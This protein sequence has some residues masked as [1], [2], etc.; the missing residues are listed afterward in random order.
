MR[1]TRAAT[2]G[3]A[4]EQ[5]KAR[6]STPGSLVALHLGAP[7]AAINADA[8]RA[9]LPVTAGPVASQAMIP[10]SRETR[11]RARLSQPRLGVDPQAAMH[12]SQVPAERRA[13]AGAGRLAILSFRRGHS[14]QHSCTSSAARVPASSIRRSPSSSAKR[15][16][17]RTARIRTARD[18]RGRQCRGPR[19]CR[20]S[21]SCVRITR[22]RFAHARISRP[23][24]AIA[25]PRTGTVELLQW[26]AAHPGRQ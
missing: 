1:S 3:A 25:G 5:P 6:R 23:C 21:T 10:R 26:T 2:I 4:L 9:A 17:G 13:T 8:A 22:R 24:V 15:V 20:R 14:R 19:L 16:P 18:L 7:L 11:Y 12:F